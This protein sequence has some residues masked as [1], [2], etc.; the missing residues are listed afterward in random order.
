M[1]GSLILAVE[2]VFNWI[3]G[4]GFK[5][6]AQYYHNASDVI[7]FCSNFIVSDGGLKLSVNQEKKST[8][9]DLDVEEIF[10]RLS[11]DIKSKIETIDL[12]GVKNI[13]YK[14]LLAIGNALPNLVHIKFQDCKHLM[15]NDD[16][17]GY[18]QAFFFNKDIHCKP[19]H[20]RILE[21]IGK[22]NFNMGTQPNYAQEQKYHLAKQYALKQIESK[23]NSWFTTDLA[24]FFSPSLIRGSG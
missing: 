9:T 24:P 1:I 15:E 23:G 16:I 4:Y 2:Q 6:D 19:S 3:L 12:S 21:S 7:K 11:S 8:L 5:T 22:D 18:I 10:T 20:Q 13:S 14:T 17:K